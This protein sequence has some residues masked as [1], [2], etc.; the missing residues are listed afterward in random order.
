VIS[1]SQFCKEHDLP[2]GSVHRYLT[3]QLGYDLALGMSDDAQA[4][5]LDRFDRRATVSASVSVEPGNHFTVLDSPNLRGQFSLEQFRDSAAVAFEDPLAVAQQFTAVADTLIGAMGADIRQR[6]ERLKQ[7]RQAQ[8]AIADKTQ[9]LRLEQRLYR[10]RAW[11]LDSAQTES[12][13]ALQSSLNQLQS[14][15]KSP[16]SSQDG[17]AS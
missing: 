9:E 8:T 17:C 1:L 13:Q 6:E 10:E 16:G 4:A 2:K 3:Q 12:T 11:M 15:G 7:A 5:A 14:L